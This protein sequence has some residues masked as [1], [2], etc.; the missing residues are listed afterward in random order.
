MQNPHHQ[1]VSVWAVSIF[2]VF[3]PLPLAIHFQEEKG[4]VEGSKVKVWLGLN[5]PAIKESHT[6]FLF[7]LKTE[8]SKHVCGK[9]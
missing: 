8:D 7:T 4:H 1:S 6:Y 3:H 9:I 5:H 2:R